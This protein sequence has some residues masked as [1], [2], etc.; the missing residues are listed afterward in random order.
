M[1]ASDSSVGG[2]AGHHFAENFLWIIPK[3]NSCY[4]KV[5]YPGDVLS[6]PSCRLRRLLKIAQAETENCQAIRL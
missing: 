2:A 3:D 1:R 4:T 5:Q 6:L